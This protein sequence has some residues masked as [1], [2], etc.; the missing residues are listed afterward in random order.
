MHSLNRTVGWSL[1]IC[2]LGLA[3][4]ASSSAA[5]GAA[6]DN[7]VGTWKYTSGTTTTNCQGTTSSENVT[8]NET[9]TKGSASDLVVSDPSCAFNFSVS[10]GTATAAPGQS[11]TVQVAGGTGMETASSLVFTTSDG[12]TG[13]VSGTFNVTESSGGASVTCTVSLTGDLQKL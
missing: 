2:G 8:G 6:T 4:C 1:F 7:F 9:I 12:K 3:G 5:G 11:C 10:G 13:H